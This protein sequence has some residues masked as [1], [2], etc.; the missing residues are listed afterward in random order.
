MDVVQKVSKKADEERVFLEGE[1]HRV[2][3]SLLLRYYNRCD[4]TKSG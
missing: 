1:I 2:N 4:V 3:V